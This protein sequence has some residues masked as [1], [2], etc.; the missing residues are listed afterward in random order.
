MLIVHPPKSFYTRV[1]PVLGLCA[2]LAV[3]GMFSG[4]SIALTVMAPQLLRWKHLFALP[5][6]L[7]IYKMLQAYWSAVTRPAEVYET[8][9]E[10]ADIN[11]WLV[12]ILTSLSVLVGL[13]AGAV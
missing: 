4:M 1:I 5:V 12:A 2:I 13:A 11:P 10:V 9:S 3:G 8:G 7:L 6:L